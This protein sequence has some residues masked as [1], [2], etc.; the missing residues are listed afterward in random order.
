MKCT[1]HVID[2]YEMIEDAYVYCY[3]SYYHNT[4]RNDTDY[5][6]GQG[7]IDDVCRI[8]DVIV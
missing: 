6:I 3:T 4:I 2:V 7:V 5:N 8:I 1:V